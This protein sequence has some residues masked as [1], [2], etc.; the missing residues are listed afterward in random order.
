MMPA[1]VM[2][3]TVP[4]LPDCVS[5]FSHFDNQLL[6][7]HCIEVGIHGVSFGLTVVDDAEQELA[8]TR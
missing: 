3:G 5:E 1:Q 8:R 2:A 4:M 6:S 7:R